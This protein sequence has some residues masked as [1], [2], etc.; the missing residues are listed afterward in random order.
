MTEGWEVAHS[1]VLLLHRATLR[2][3]IIYLQTDKEEDPDVP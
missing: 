2:L 3:G 1:L